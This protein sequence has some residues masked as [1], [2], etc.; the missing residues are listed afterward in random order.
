[1]QKLSYF[2]YFLPIFLKSQFTFSE[3]SN[4]E[5]FIAADEHINFGD[6]R[7]TCFGF[8][9]D[10]LKIDNQQA[11]DEVLAFVTIPVRFEFWIGLRRDDN[12]LDISNPL[13]YKFLDGTTFTPGGFGSVGQLFPW[14]NDEPGAPPSDAAC[15]TYSDVTGG[16]STLPC[17]RGNTRY[18][19]K[20]PCTEAPSKGPTS[21]PTFLPTLNPTS[22]ITESPS[23]NPTRT[24]TLN[25]SEKPT[26]RPTKKPSKS[27]T[28]SPN[29]LTSAPTAEEVSIDDKFDDCYLYILLVL[30]LCCCL[31]LVFIFCIFVK[32]SK[33]RTQLVNESV[34]NEK[35]L[36][37]SA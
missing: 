17:V 33:T 11:L 3:C 27:P 31:L 23:F 8:G 12:E 16:L 1:M 37:L 19:C 5:Q 35:T 22:F 29:V 15:V 7:E 30:I 24:P 32:D 13:V 36:K 9:G 34:E 10:L 2:L 6:A 18:V 21:S 25:P 20:A 26:I 14:E 28:K 4:G